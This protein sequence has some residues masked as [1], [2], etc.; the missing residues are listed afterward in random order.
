[1]VDPALF[2]SKGKNSPWAGSL[3]RGKVMATVV[4]GGIVY[5]DE[6]ANIETRR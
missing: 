2:A 4:G 6:T 5:D 3:L 1:V